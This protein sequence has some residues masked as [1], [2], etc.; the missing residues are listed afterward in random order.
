MT[1]EIA[2]RLCAYRKSKGFSQEEL[3]EKLGVTRQAV[4]KW[5]RA[6][7]SPDTD[8]LILLSEIYEVTLDDLLYKD[9]E[10]AIE[11]ET[12]AETAQEKKR[13]DKVSFKNGIH[14]QSEDGDKVDIDFSGIHVDTKDTNVHIGA[15]GIHVEDDGHIHVH[16][17]REASSWYK[18]WKH[19]PWPIICCVIYL[20]MGFLDVWGGWTFGWL[21]FLTVPL[22]YSLGSAIEFRN[23][24]FFAYPVLVVLA[25]LIMGFFYSLWHPGWILFLTV[26]VYYWICNLFKKKQNEADEVFPFEEE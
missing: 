12:E 2:N 9:P 10:P 8:K 3:A 21:I 13:K 26:P 6:E 4:S 25:Y 14:I 20:I 7:A 22:Y 1:I 17:E 5:E 18:V 19:F 16:T 23:G 15:E 24:H 11:P